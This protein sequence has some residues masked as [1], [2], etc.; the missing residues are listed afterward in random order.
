MH[1]ENNNTLFGLY[2]T[3]CIQSTWDVGGARAPSTYVAASL[4]ACAQTR[5]LWESKRRALHR[6]TSTTGNTVDTNNG[7]RAHHRPLPSTAGHTFNTEVQAGNTMRPP[8][9]GGLTFRL[10]ACARRGRTNTT[11]HHYTP[12]CPIREATGI[13]RPNLP[14]VADPWRLGGAKW[15]QGHNTCSTTKATSYDK[16]LAHQCADVGLCDPHSASSERRQG[17]GPWRVATPNIPPRKRPCLKWM[18][19]EMTGACDR[20]GRDT[21]QPMRR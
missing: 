14:Q 8:S 18:P 9:L 13:V 6:R 7:Y 4:G 15:V 2:I 5:P 10:Q 19:R 16:R 21:A 12:P 11:I 1:G 20:H 3:I 17:G